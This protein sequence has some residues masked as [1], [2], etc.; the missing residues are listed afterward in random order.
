MVAG[1]L[2][3]DT[4]RKMADVLPGSCL[5]IFKGMVRT[6]EQVLRLPTRVAP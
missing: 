2:E 6:L 1:N 3:S 4:G 5:A